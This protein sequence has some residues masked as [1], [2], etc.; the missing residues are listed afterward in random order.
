MLNNFH[1][2]IQSTYETKNNLKS[3]FLVVMLCLDKENIVTAV[4]EKVTNADVY[5]NWLSVNS[6][7]ISDLFKNRII[8][9]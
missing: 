9:H 5:L 7:C 6:A 3:A 4:Y 1:P 2:N 8:R